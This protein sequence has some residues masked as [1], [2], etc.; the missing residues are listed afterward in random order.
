MLRGVGKAATNPSRAST[1]TLMLALLGIVVYIN[2][3]HLSQPWGAGGKLGLGSALVL[4]HG[5]A[6]VSALALIWWRDHAQV[7]RWLA[8][9]RQTAAA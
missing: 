4:L 2:L 3:I 5:G 1:W 9:R 7:T 6:L 8:W